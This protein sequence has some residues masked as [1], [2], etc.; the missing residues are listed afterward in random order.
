MSGSKP[1]PNRGEPR[2]IDEDRALRLILE[3]TVTETGTQFLRQLVRNLCRALDTKA[4]WVS[5]WLPEQRR[6][7]SLAFWMDQGWVDHYEYA[8]DG[9]PC[10]PV[11]DNCQLALFTD[12]V[13]E[14]FPQDTDLRPM[15]AVS[16]IGTPLLDVDGSIIGHLAVMDSEPLPEDEKLRTVFEVFAER[17]AAEVRRLGAERRL[18]DSEE[19]LSRLLDSAMDAVLVFDD[20]RRIVRVNPA[21][22]RALGTRVAE[23]LG[24]HVHRFIETDSTDEFDS[25]IKCMGALP[26]EERRYWFPRGLGAR[27]ADGTPFPAEATLSC[28]E[29]RKNKVFH[30]LILRDVNERVEAERRLQLLADEAEYLREAVGEAPGGGEILGKSAGMRRL[31]EAIEQVA[32]TDTTVLIL[33]ETGTGKELVARAIHEASPRKNKP[34]VRVNCAAIP[35]TLMESEFFGH[36]RGAFTGATSR[37]EGRFALADAGT[38]FLDEVGELPLDL[39]AK[40]LRVLQEGEFEMLGGSRTHKVDV[41][42]LAATHRNPETMVR[43]KVFR[44]DLFYRINVFPVEVPTLRDRKDDLVLLAEAFA[45]RYARRMGRAVEPIGPADIARLKA[46]DWPG[47][48]RELQNV[49]E[50]SLILSSSGRLALDRAM[51]RAGEASKPPESDDAGVPEGAVL[52]AVEWQDLERRNLRRALEATGWRVAGKSGAAAMLGVPPST[53]TSRMKALGLE[54]QR[55]STPKKL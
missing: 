30:T 22:G 7:R 38:I 21:A 50:R 29:T 8:I 19:Q 23:L 46:Y 1:T 6:L 27:R 48:V 20:D 41:R 3:G 28:F 15:E 54:R 12:N 24:V 51:P 40:L 16:Y 25:R 37:R 9:T 39:Q 17:A 13:I 4:A 11:I 53:L 26:L 45:A 34:L 5:E 44:E 33:G 42:V 32:S 2:K 35:V 31:F 43:D 52:T 55:G 14:M 36:E 49:I 10:Q 47:N 18:R